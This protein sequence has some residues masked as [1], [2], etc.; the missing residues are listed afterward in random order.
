MLQKMLRMSSLL[1][2]Y[3][4]LLTDKQREICAEYYLNDLSLGEIAE[5]HGVTRQAVHDTLLRA[6]RTMEAYEAHFGLMARESELAAHLDS[7]GAHLAAARRLIA[8]GG[9]HAAEAA[10]RAIGAAEAA[11]GEMRARVSPEAGSD[12]RRDG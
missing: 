10:M 11:L 9:P 1:D 2:V 5:A 7:L 8:G 3:G 6:G 4:V 12:A